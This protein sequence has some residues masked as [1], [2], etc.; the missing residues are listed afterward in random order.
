ML[1]RIDASKMIP[2][3]AAAL[4]KEMQVFSYGSLLDDF[5]VTI[6]T[7]TYKQEVQ[8]D[9]NLAADA[10]LKVL[11]SQGATN[12][13]VKTED[14][15]TQKGITGKKAYGTMT[16]IDKIK[17]TSNKMYYELLLFGQNNGL[18]QIMVLHRDDDK[19]GKQIT[20]RILNSV[21]LK[22]AD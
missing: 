22:V 17:G 9:L 2:K 13:L 14:Y 5:Y 4:I 8:P 3:E 18:Q 10:S 11:E 21:E 12:I 15:D 1:Q 7:A 6:N 20:E 16:M 19:Y